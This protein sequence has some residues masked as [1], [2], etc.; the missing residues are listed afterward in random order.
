MKFTINLA[1]MID[2]KELIQGI[3]TD[4]ILLFSLVIDITD[5]NAMRL[6]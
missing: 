2:K 1:E 3:K 4:S 5:I 6:S